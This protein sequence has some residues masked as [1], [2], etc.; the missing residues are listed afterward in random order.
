MQFMLF[1]HGKLL[2]SSWLF[3]AC[4][5]LEKNFFIVLPKYCHLKAFLNAAEWHVH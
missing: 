5:S 3:M 4:L 2:L 1:F